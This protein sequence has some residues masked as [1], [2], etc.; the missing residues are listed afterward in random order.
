MVEILFKNAPPQDLAEIK[1]KFNAIAEEKAKD[2]NFT[3][4]SGSLPLDSSMV[5]RVLLEYYRT[6]KKAKQFIIKRL[7]K[8]QGGS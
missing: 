1:D 3:E 5:L 4:F 7:F 8:E 6:E 2:Y